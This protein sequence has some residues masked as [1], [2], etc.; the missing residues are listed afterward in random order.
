VAI[1]A[2]F[3]DPDDPFDEQRVVGAGVAVTEQPL[4][5]GCVDWLRRLFGLPEKIRRQLLEHRV[6]AKESSAIGRVHAALSTA[7]AFIRGAGFQLPLKPADR[8]P[9]SAGRDFGALQDPL[10]VLDIALAR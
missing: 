3:R 1:G 8:L 9:G 6:N 5:R 2:G 4:T 10:G 7:G